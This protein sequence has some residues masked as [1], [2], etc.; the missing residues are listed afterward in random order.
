MSADDLVSAM[1]GLS[2]EEPRHPLYETVRRLREGEEPLLESNDVEGIA[3]Y[4][5]EHDAKN[6]IVAWFAVQ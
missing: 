6:I 2:L 3:K 4:I 1:K 5:I